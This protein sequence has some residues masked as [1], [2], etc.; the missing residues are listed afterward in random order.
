MSKENFLQ[1]FDLSNKLND[2][3]ISAIN[4]F[5]NCV[6]N[7]L[8]EAMKEKNIIDL[9]VRDLHISKLVYYN[10]E[11]HLEEVENLVLRDNKI[12]LDYFLYDNEDNPIIDDFSKLD[13]YNLLSIMKE[14]QK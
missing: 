10:N 12:V 1:M 2:K 6:E 4:D 3:V 7:I 11:Y 5:R 8:V 9:D 14:I 13:Y